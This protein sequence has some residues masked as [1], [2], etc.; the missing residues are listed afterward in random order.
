MASVNLAVEAIFGQ[1]S[2][3]LRTTPR[4]YLFEGIPFCV[5]PG[6]IGNIVCNVVKQKK[7]KSVFEFSK[8]M[9]FAYFYH[10]NII[11]LF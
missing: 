10:V 4:K 3:F 9:K 1:K 5:N 8:G 7:S 6:I 2:L 11:E